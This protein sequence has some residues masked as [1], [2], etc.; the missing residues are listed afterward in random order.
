MTLPPPGDPT[1]I[2]PEPSPLEP[3]LPG[4]PPDPDVVEGAAGDPVVSA[5]GLLPGALAG[6]AVGAAV[7]LAP[8]A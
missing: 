2:E 8:I 5:G 6:I 4:Q 3:D 1:P 7:I